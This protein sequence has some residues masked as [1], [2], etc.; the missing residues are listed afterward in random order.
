MSCLWKACIRQPLKSIPENYIINNEYNPGSQ[1]SQGS[2]SQGSDSQGVLIVLGSQGSDISDFNVFYSPEQFKVFISKNDKWERYSIVRGIAS[3]L[4]VLKR[5]YWNT[6][7]QY[8]YEQFKKDDTKLSHLENYYY[9]LACLQI[10]PSVIDRDTY[11][12]YID[13]QIHRTDYDIRHFYKK[14]LKILDASYNKS[15]YSVNKKIIKIFKMDADYIKSI[16]NS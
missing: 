9:F 15:S 13:L 12:I 6:Y 5:Q 4:S 16:N 1:G 7:E 3:V 2:D 10:Q 8:L 14:I 11:D